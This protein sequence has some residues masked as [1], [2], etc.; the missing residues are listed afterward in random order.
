MVRPLLATAALLALI[1]AGIYLAEAPARFESVRQ[2][3]LPV[4]GKT[5]LAASLL[6]V[7]WWVAY[8]ALR[9][10]V[11]ARVIARAVCAAA[12]LA[13]AADWA[14]FLPPGGPIAIGLALAAGGTYAWMRL[15]PA[16]EGS[17]IQQPVR[18]ALWILVFTALASSGVIHVGSAIRD[19]SARA[20]TTE[21][22]TVPRVILVVVDSLR[23][24][25]LACYG[26]TNPTPHM[27]TL[28]ADAVV[29][30]RARAPAPWT[31][32]SMASLMT[33]ASPWVHRVN[34]AH[35]ALPTGWST[36]A[37]Q[38]DD[39]GY[40]TGA[41]GR[42]R[43]LVD[44]GFDQGF[45]HFD[46]YPRPRAEMPLAKVFP[47]VQKRHAARHASTE[48]LADRA[49]HWITRERHVDFFLWLHLFDP[50]QPYTPPA[51]Y[52]PDTPDTGR[53]GDAFDQLDEVRDGTFVPTPAEVERVREL[54]LAEVRFVDDQIG[55]LMDRL[56]SMGLYDDTL[57]VLTSDHGEE[58]WEHGGY[59]H[60]HTLYEELLRVPLLVKVPGT[61]PHREPAPASLE[62]V[63]PHILH[64]CGVTT[65]PPAARDLHHATANL[66]GPP[67]QSVHFGPHKLIHDRDTGGHTLYDLVTDPGEVRDLAPH[68]PEQAIHARGQLADHPPP[69]AEA[70]DRQTAAA[71]AQVDLSEGARDQLRELGYID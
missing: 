44:R 22:H 10:R 32:P 13:Y 17:P 45:Q 6:A 23:A 16:R 69:A 43:F 66:Y 21:G 12:V 62:D 36:L 20:G 70:P 34:T 3:L 8:R 53:V 65:D 64:A 7:L 24:D 15:L 19:G 11:D 54:Y 42:N 51:D 68:H 37:E 56:K 47:F 5:L 14:S 48:Q 9:R 41:I 58:L 63:T 46:L 39:S 55:R 29:F 30:D 50:H 28:A 25:A 38:L 1:D 49:I 57:I 33:G 31:L 67:L 40:R 60:G 71:P 52:L 59:E 2:A 35:S 18:A 26:S 27:D 4:T 61:A